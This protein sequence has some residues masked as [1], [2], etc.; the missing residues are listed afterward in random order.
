MFNLPQDPE[1]KENF[2][3]ALKFHFFPRLLTVWDLQRILDVSFLSIEE[4]M[5]GNFEELECGEG[6]ERF[7]NSALLKLR[8]IYEMEGGKKVLRKGRI[9]DWLISHREGIKALVESGR[10][11]LAKSLT[12]NLAIYISFLL[13]TYISS[14]SLPSKFEKFFGEAK[15][16]EDCFSPLEAFLEDEQWRQTLEAMDFAPHFNLI[17]SAH[18]YNLSKNIETNGLQESVK[19]ILTYKDDLRENFEAVEAVEADKLSYHTVK[20]LEMAAVMS[21][22]LEEEWGQ[23]KASELFEKISDRLAD[24]KG[25]SIIDGVL[26]KFFS[27]VSAITSG[28]KCKFAEKFQSIGR[29]LIKEKLSMMGMTE[30]LGLTIPPTLLATITQSP[31]P[32]ID[33]FGSLNPD[34]VPLLINKAS[35]TLANW[36]SAVKSLLFSLFGEYPATAKEVEDIMKDATASSAFLSLLGPLFPYIIDTI[37]I[38]HKRGYEEE[39]VNEL[40]EIVTRIFEEKLDILS[41][42]KEKGKDTNFSRILSFFAARDVFWAEFRLFSEEV[43]ETIKNYAA[44][45]ALLAVLEELKEYTDVTIPAPIRRKKKRVPEEIQDMYI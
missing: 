10:K 21:L 5:G 42:L 8:P 14:Q 35:K 7:I 44:G 6:Q 31:L 13:T 19:H 33:I 32:K 18:L 16:A 39:K 24:R 27:A 43:G 4:I 1:K 12:R 9:K 23:K 38:A 45:D 20:T 15:F 26:S 17:I 40:I 29:K 25:S 22:H 34:E 28:T 3:S 37:M 2:F 11:T 41:N 30:K 36:S